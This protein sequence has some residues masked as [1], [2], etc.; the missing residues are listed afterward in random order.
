MSELTYRELREWA[1]EDR[2]RRAMD[3]F[4]ID[5]TN[6][7]HPYTPLK[8]GF[9]VELS[10]PVIKL[11]VKGGLRP[12]QL[13]GIYLASSFIAL[14]LVFTGNLIALLAALLIFLINGSLNWADGALAR[15]T[16]QASEISARFDPMAGRVKQ[17][18]F[19]SAVRA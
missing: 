18:A 4:E 19:V 12:N 13:T 9:Y 10:L 8:S 16:G 3:G 1:R 5:F 2:K 17:V 14:A 11:A 7:K 15:S 6:W